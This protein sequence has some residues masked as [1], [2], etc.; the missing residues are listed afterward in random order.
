M[1]LLKKEYP[2]N[3]N[4]N[5]HNIHLS[6]REINTIRIVI[7]ATVAPWHQ[8]NPIWRLS[9]LAVC[10]HLNFVFQSHGSSVVQ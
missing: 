1:Y 10:I 7:V 6:D 8:V 5:K 4:E 2:Y 9:S 3:Y